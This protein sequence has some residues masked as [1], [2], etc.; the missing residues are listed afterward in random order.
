MFG[1][2]TNIDRSRAGCLDPMILR[3]ASHQVKHLS[4]L[5]LESFEQFFIQTEER[6]RKKKEKERRRKK[7]KEERRRKK[8]ERK[9]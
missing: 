2:Y 1:S 8:K 3:N 9:F 4:S 7:K 5:S 6:K